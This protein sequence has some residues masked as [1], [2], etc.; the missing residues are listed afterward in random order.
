MFEAIP[1]NYVFLVQ[2]EIYTEDPKHYDHISNNVMAHLWTAKHLTQTAERDC[3]RCSYSCHAN[4]GYSSK[5]F[6][7]C[8]AVPCHLKCALSN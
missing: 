2:A 7:L 1:N 6:K 5:V 8:V 4:S 3:I